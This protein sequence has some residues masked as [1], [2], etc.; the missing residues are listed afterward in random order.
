MKAVR[1]RQLFDGLDLLA[2]PVVLVDGATVVDVGRPPPAGVELTDL[3]D[4]TLLPG[5]VPSPLVAANKPTIRGAL[6]EL[7]RR[8]ATVEG[9]PLTDLDALLDVRAV[10]RAGRQQLPDAD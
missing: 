3:G 6:R 1:A 8:G 9:D 2:E 7:R 10:W 5:Y 4:M